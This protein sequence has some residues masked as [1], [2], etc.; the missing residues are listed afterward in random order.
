MRHSNYAHSVGLSG[1]VSRRRGGA[2][3]T[4]LRGI[5]NWVRNNPQS[6]VVSVVVRLGAGKIEKRLHIVFVCVEGAECRQIAAAGIAFGDQ[7]FSG[8]PCE[9]R[10]AA[11]YG[12]DV[13]KH[14]GVAAVSIG[15]RMN[16]RQFVVKTKES[17]VSRESPMV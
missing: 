16:S 15:E 12:H 10:L 6:K 13:G 7:I 2:G 1:T 3:N 9:F 17:F 11:F 14:S 5:L 8:S 4:E